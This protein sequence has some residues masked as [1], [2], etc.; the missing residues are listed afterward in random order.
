ME[1]MLNHSFVLDALEATAA[2]TFSH[3]EML[4]EEHRCHSQSDSSPN[5][6]PS[7]LKQLVP[8]V[9]TFHTHLPLRKAFMAYNKKYALTKRK[10]VRI[11]FN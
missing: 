9:G 10:F 7:R 1:S 3:F 11:S 5:T 8:T 4:I 6:H 2:D